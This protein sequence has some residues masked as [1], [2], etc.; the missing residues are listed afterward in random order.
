MARKPS[1]DDTCLDDLLE[2]IICFGPFTNP[3]V[4]QCGHTFC[5]ECLQKHHDASQEDRRRPSASISCPTCREKTPI[6]GEPHGGGSPKSKTV[7]PS[8]R[9]DVYAVRVSQQEGWSE[10]VLRQLWRQLLW[11]LSTQTQRKPSL[12]W[13]YCCRQVDTGGLGQDSTS[14]SGMLVI[15][16]IFHWCVCY[17]SIYNDVLCFIFKWN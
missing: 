6:Q 10:G 13:S 2:C 9:K 8:F 17:G 11:G 12:Q 14:V 3:K 4:L 7:Q 1:I 5:Q 16:L 15:L